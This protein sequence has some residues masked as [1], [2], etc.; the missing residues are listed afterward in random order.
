[1]D[2]KIELTKDEI[3]KIENPGFE[4]KEDIKKVFKEYSKIGPIELPCN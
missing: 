3:F 4:D 2:D 1:L